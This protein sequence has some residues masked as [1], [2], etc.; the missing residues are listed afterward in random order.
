MTRGKP[1]TSPPQEATQ[2]RQIGLDHAILLVGLVCAA[3]VWIPGGASDPER[4][5]VPKESVLHLSVLVAICAAMVR[6]VVIEYDAIDVLV[7]LFAS[8]GWLSVGLVAQNPWAGIRAAAVS[9]SGALV[10][11]M[12]RRLAPSAKM[13]VA[14]AVIAIGTGI[15]IWVLA[16]AHGLIP[17][18]SLTSRAPG[19]PLGNRSRAA[20]LLAIILPVGLAVASTAH[21]RL[22]S[23][24][25]VGG[26]AAMAAAIVITRSRA[27][28]LAAA[29]AST[30]VLV[31]QLWASSARTRRLTL[32][33]YAALAIGC[34]FAILLPPNLNWRSASPYRD[35]LAHLVD[36]RSGSG[37]VRVRQS[38]TT[39]EMAKANPILGV[40]P[41][42]WQLAYGRYARPDDPSY[43]P[44]LAVPTNRLPQ[45]DWFGILAERGAIAFALLLMIGTGII[46]RAWVT[47]KADSDH[48][49]PI[50]TGG[51]GAVGATLIVGSGDPV[52]LT[53]LGIYVVALVTATLLPRSTPRQV[54][55]NVTRGLFIFAA[56]CMSTLALAYSG[57]QVWSTTLLRNSPPSILALT[58]AAR[59]DPGDYLSRVQLAHLWELLRRCDLALPYAREAA[60]LFPTAV[61]PAIIVTRCKH[62]S[63]E[64]SRPPRASRPVAVP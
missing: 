18:T 63:E 20:H 38:A 31:I 32:R 64:T 10:F 21:D 24:L 52:V 15:A 26:T 40:G 27:G 33:A 16:E 34:A 37:E 59:I 60:Q 19:G 53:G 8:L 44:W 2:A 61:A 58:R 54:A 55:S 50:A 46:A 56:C 4:F 42:N 13:T 47:L 45:G 23:V 43:T 36:V 9:M 39:F 3:A 11:Y 35:T 5:A 62:E 6:R 14:F 17:P 12:T 48:A 51:L 49:R 7:F 25:V 30:T 41:G 1:L 57:R 28:W 22:G 29:L